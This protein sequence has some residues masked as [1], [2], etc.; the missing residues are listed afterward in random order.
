MIKIITKVTLAVLLLAVSVSKA[1]NFQGQAFYKSKTNMDGS[2]KIESSS[3]TEEMKQKFMESMKKEFEKEYILTFNKSESVYEEEQKLDAPEP[4]AGG[5]MIK[6]ENS[7]DGKIYKNIKDKVSITE[8]EFFGKE[9]LIT[10]SLSTYQWKIEG[11]SKKIGEYTCYKATYT[12]PVSEKEKEEYANFKNKQTD[13]KTQFLMMD[14]PKEQL[15]SVWYT[16]EIP[17]SNGPG[18]YWGLP[19]LILEAS[20]DKTVVLCSKLILNPKDKLIIKVPKTGKK[21]TK[22]EYESLVQKQMELM[23]SQRGDGKDG[24]RIEVHR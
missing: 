11:E 9:F 18:E 10:D 14:E 15:I 8:E 24:I 5:M 21:V 13:S 7:N 17:I 2:L 4:S 20:F 6:M 23:N 19:G 3:M 16:P 22:S 12:I 1:Q